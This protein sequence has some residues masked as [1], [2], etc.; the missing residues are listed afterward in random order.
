MLTVHAHNS[1]HVLVRLVVGHGDDCHL[2]QNSGVD[3]FAQSVAFDSSFHVKDIYSK[4][5]FSVIFSR[6]NMFS[7]IVFS[8]GKNSLL[9]MS[10]DL[11]LQLSHQC[12]KI[13][14]LKKKFENL[15]IVNN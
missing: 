8:R 10:K 15:M 13:G 6:G 5:W 4:K 1:L 11:S 14:T 2:S 12:E 9:F 7:L 3:W